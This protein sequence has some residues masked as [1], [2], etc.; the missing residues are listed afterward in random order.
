MARCCL[1]DTSTVTMPCARAYACTHVRTCTGTV[2]H[3]GTP[4]PVSTPVHPTQ[5][6]TVHHGYAVL[7]GTTK[8]RIPVS[9]NRA[10]GPTAFVLFLRV[11]EL[12]AAAE[13]S[14]LRELAAAVTRLL[15]PLKPVSPNV[16]GRRIGHTGLAA[17]RE[18]RLAA[19]GHTADIKGRWP[20]RPREGLGGIEAYE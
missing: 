10:C 11:A 15:D 20:V 3:A 14:G 12:E 2:T 5:H 9:T 8:P 16:S 7:Y 18:E 19:P 1:T 4:C 6:S 13:V 17:G